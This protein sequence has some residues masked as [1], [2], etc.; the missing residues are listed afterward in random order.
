MDLIIEKYISLLAK[1][2]L[3]QTAKVNLTLIGSGNH[4]SHKLHNVNSTLFH[5]DANV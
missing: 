5:N 1:L 4:G 3:Y 2:K